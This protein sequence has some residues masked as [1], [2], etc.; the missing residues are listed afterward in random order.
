MC[1]WGGMLGCGSSTLEVCTPFIVV[2][3]YV[4]AERCILSWIYICPIVVLA[5][6][7]CG[8][9]TAF[10]Q[11]TV[12]GCDAQQGDC[13]LL[14]CLYTYGCSMTTNYLWYQELQISELPSSAIR[15]ARI[16]FS[17]YEILGCVLKTM[18]LQGRPS[19]Q[20]CSSSRPY[21]NWK[22]CVRF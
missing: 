15:T 14:W 12:L 22:L 16:T 19:E 8:A 18:Y 1:F 10:H 7:H 11:V 2:L 13:I 5:R 17:S 4:I 20:L 9:F 6:G 21:W 3:V